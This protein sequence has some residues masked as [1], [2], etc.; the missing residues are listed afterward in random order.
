MNGK[1][2]QVAV[3]EKSLFQAGTITD[4]YILWAENRT[5]EVTAIRTAEYFDQVFMSFKSAFHLM[6][7]LVAFH[8]TLGYLSRRHVTL[9]RNSKLHAKLKMAFG[10]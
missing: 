9:Q 10:R 3:F 8:K 6:D 1:R 5:C 4:D 7:Q 2:Q